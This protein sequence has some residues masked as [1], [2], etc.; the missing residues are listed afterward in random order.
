MT[1]HTVVSREDWLAARLALLEREKAHTRERDALSAARLALP[2]VRI[3]KDYV[4]EGPEG[5]VGF[6][7]L[8]QGRSQLIIQHFMF[9]PD[10]EEGCPGCSLTADHVDGARQHLEQRGV[11]FAAVSRASWE[12]IARFRKRMGWG[13][14]WVSSAGS[15]FNFDF[16]VSFT[17]EEMAR[18]EAIYNYRLCKPEV[19]EYGG[20]SAFFRDGDGSIFHTYS[21]YGRGDEAMMG[22][23]A[24]L[25][26]APL[27]RNETGPNGDLGDWV[28]HHDRYEVASGGHCCGGEA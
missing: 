8:F 27:G 23:Y 10:W 26:I 18:G 14:R 24:Y 22:V 19:E 17:P 1:N 5:R 20:T 4:F 6:G 3:D 7:D 12:K 2:W 21:T 9:G 11:S 15:S 13:F 25:D 16:G 28:R